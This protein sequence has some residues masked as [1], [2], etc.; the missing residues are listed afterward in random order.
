MREREARQGQVR[1]R[2][3]ENKK[4]WIRVRVERV[5]LVKE[6]EGKG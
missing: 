3:G 4:G 1:D 5:L 6:R 2:D